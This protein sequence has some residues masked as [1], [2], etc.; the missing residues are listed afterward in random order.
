MATPGQG[1]RAKSGVVRSWGDAGQ[2]VR[3]EQSSRHPETQ[4]I[5]DGRQAQDWCRPGGRP[6]WASTA[7]TNPGTTAT[8]AGG[9][10][11]VLTRKGGDRMRVPLVPPSPRHRGMTVPGAPLATRARCN[12][13]RLAG[14]VRCATGTPMRPAGPRRR[15][16]MRVG[17]HIVSGSPGP[18]ISRSPSSGIARRTVMRRR[19]FLGLIACLGL[20]LAAVAPVTAGP[21]TPGPLVQVSG[22]SAFLG[23][24]A[25]AVAGQSG[26]VYLNSEVEPWIDVNPTNPANVVGIWQQDRWSNGGARGLVAGV[27][28][29]GGSSWS[30]SRGSR[31]ARAAPT[32]ARPTPGS[33]SAPTGRCI[34]WPCPST[35]SHRR[36]CPPTSTMPCWPAARPTA[37]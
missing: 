11:Q 12:R 7:T 21:L 24:T 4:D 27:S 32:S 23:C 5:G 26:T 13:D 18:A 36:S 19:V 17:R 6:T 22:T 20:G 29:N 25:D 3:H 35:T 28:S 10:C 16:A 9:G 33:A 14:V 34:S 30:R 2:G 15:G 37:D 8:S 1:T 31:C